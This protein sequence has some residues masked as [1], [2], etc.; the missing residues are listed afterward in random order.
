M[1]K[2]PAPVEEHLPTKRT[3]TNDLNQ[4]NVDVNKAK[5]AC[6]PAV[7]GSTNK[8]FGRP[9]SK[10]HLTTISSDDTEYDTDA[11]I[12]ERHS[13]F[14]G[15][16]ARDKEAW[17]I[18]EEV[19]HTLP[20]DN[21]PDNTSSSEGR[22]QSPR[23]AG[24]PPAPLCSWPQLHDDE[25]TGLS[26][27][28]EEDSFFFNKWYWDQCWY[29]S[30]GDCSQASGGDQQIDLELEP[31]PPPTSSSVDFD[32]DLP[33]WSA[34]PEPFRPLH[35]YVKGLR[36]AIH[37]HETSLPFYCPQQQQQQPQE[38]ENDG[39]SN[40]TPSNHPDAGS[41]EDLERR[42]SVSNRELRATT[43][44]ELCLN[45]PPL[46][47]RT[48]THEPAR[49]LVIVDTIRAR[50]G[51]GAQLV[52]CRL[53][54]EPTR[55]YVAKIYD[56]LYYGFA[57]PSWPDIPRDVATE[58]DRAYCAEVAAYTELS[59]HHHHHH[60]DEAFGV[61]RELDGLVPRFYGSWTF[62]LLLDAP[63][64]T[65]VA[66]DVRMILTERIVGGKSMDQV[67]TDLLPETER[68]AALRLLME[69]KARLKGAGVHVH[70]GAVVSPET[71]VICGL[72][73]RVGSRWATTTCCTSS[74]RPQRA[75]FVD[76]GRAT[77]GRLEEAGASRRSDKNEGKQKNKLL[78]NPLV[79]WWDESLYAHYGKWLPAGWEGRL[80][81]M[82]AWLWGLYGDVGEVAYQPVDKTSLRWA[83][84]D[85]MAHVIGG[86]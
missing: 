71:V 55:E 2:R 31:P 68:L 34:P 75:V 54:D 7:R 38:E 73:E 52:V 61:V 47:G 8:D 39:D 27:Q 85:E 69:G 29:D 62:Q 64:G 45:Y 63:D 44:V 84:E 56:P 17:W 6:C 13:V 43:V 46:A 53:D 78:P 82:Q 32:Q 4:T 25:H 16:D 22:N 24:S 21:E 57:D 5:L 80:R 18:N 9:D 20:S 86:Q 79:D 26:T 42:G 14:D 28:E 11:T 36:L 48:H 70:P 10:A 19:E 59:S 74:P 23:T 30:S 60:D 83:D 58:A 66:R 51:H 81:P 35:P 77:V 72:N 1:G 41:D 33:P 65:I 37:R 12:S 3:K 50:D 40:D 67:R 49:Q 76:L 15:D